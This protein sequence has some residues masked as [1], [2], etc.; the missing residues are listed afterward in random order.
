MVPTECP[1][2]KNEVPAKS[3]FCNGCGAPLRPDPCRHCG[4]VN[5][6][7]ALTCRRC[8]G[9]LQAGIANPSAALMR[10]RAWSGEAASAAQPAH[11]TGEPPHY[12]S[13]L[14]DG[15]DRGSGPATA[16]D[17][18][19]DPVAYVVRFEQDQ[20]VKIGAKYELDIPLPDVQ[21]ER[22]LVSGEAELPSLGAPPMPET[23]L[24]VAQPAQTL[25]PATALVSLGVRLP[26][27]S[28]RTLPLWRMPLFLA[29]VSVA[30]LAVGL[31]LMLRQQSF[32]ELNPPP[33]SRP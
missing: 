13:L 33:S 32:V 17:E 24:A 7:D 19:R 29:G 11:M 4:V 22:G 16:L 15:F 3:R 18:H 5:A 20:T 1:I 9:E 6:A 30:A 25:P 28:P 10:F 8:G 27:V 23:S 14:G 21:P 26:P 31:Y 12:A 2:C